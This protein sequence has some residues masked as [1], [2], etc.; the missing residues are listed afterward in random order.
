[1]K[2]ILCQSYKRNTMKIKLN[3]IFRTNEDTSHISWNDLTKGRH[4]FSLNR[5]KGMPYFAEV[6]GRVPL[7]NFHCNPFKEDEE[8]TPWRNMIFQDEGRVL[9]NGDNKDA[10]LQ[11]N[12]TF[13]NKQVLSILNL[14]SSKDPRERAKAPPIFVTKT[15]KLNG[16]T[17]YRKFIGFGI[18]DSNPVLVQQYEKGTDKVFSN[19]QFK[20]SLLTLGESGKFDWA[21]IDDRRDPNID[22]TH[23]NDKA[24]R[25]W[26]E[27]VKNGNSNLEKIRLNIKSYKVLSD[28]EQRNYSEKN[29]KII[30]DLLNVHYP[31]ATV[32][33]IRFEAL[34]SFITSLYFDNYN[35]Q[36][37][38]ITESTGDRGVDFVGR[39]DIGDDEFS[40]TSL[41][42]LGQSKRYKKPISGERLTRVASRMTRGHIG[43]V[44][45]L[46]TFTRQ[47]Q[48]EINDDKLP[49]ILINGKKVSELL[50]NYMNKTNRTLTSIV[51]EQDQWAK[52]NLGTEHYENILNT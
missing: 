28:S 9:Y 47:A 43:V 19:Y 14:Y 31:N 40:K 37:G 4:E 51:E 20:V 38:W 10:S 29:Q 32:D 8:Q 7:I 44:V 3:Q 50:L 26:L 17:G 35:Y 34:A 5:F 49:I 27:W 16:K 21:W 15:V 46:D 30:N 12:D 45:T 33:G 42:V 18:I 6:E 52:I 1:M 48:H 36:R 23:S 39:L 41:I 2:S 22:W 25:A 24:P 11:A 13:G